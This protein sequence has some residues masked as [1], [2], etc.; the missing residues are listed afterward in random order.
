MKLL[1]HHIEGEIRIWENITYVNIFDRESDSHMGIWDN[2]AAISGVGSFF[3]CPMEK[4]EVNFIYEV[5]DNQ[6]DLY[7][8]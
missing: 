3:D 5:K 2:H 8:F 7:I 6:V 4:Q 1:I